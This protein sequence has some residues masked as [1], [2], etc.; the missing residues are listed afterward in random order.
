MNAFA[1]LFEALDQTTKTNARLDALVSYFNEASHEDAL[2]CIALLTHRRPKRTVNT[3]LLRE[4]AAEEAGIPLWL[5]E[6]TY[7]IVGDLAETIALVTQPVYRPSGREAEIHTTSLSAV[8]RELIALHDADEQTKRAYVTRQWSRFDQTERL[9]FNKLITGGF[10]MGV[11]A[12]NLTKALALFTGKDV[13]ALAHRLMGN[14]DPRT[15]RFADLVLSDDATADA[16][17]PYPFFLAY[18]VEGGTESLGTVE[19]YLAED[20]WDG[21]RA[22]VIV[23]NGELFIWSRGEELVTDKYP[24]LAHLV[25]V[26]PNGT[27]IDGELVCHSGSEVLPFALLQTRIGR[28]TVSKKLLA[29]APVKIIAY[30]LLEHGG[31]D[32]RMLPQHERRSMLEDLHAQTASESLLL[33]RLWV[34][35]SWDALA[36]VRESARERQSEGLMLKHRDAPYEVGRKRG[37]WWKWKLDPYTV[38]AVM[39]YAMRGHG[40][41]ANLYTDYTFAVWNADGELVPFTKAYSGLTD[42]EFAEVDRFVKANTLERF[43]P[44]RSVTPALVFE[45]A[46]EGIARSPR[47]KSGIA[48]RFPR[49]VRI[50]RDKKPEEAGTLGELEGLL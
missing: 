43:G 34:S 29:E 24:E 19:E 36:A 48:L 37:A 18:P 2:W 10:R 3:R 20:K 22:Q 1:R 8:M 13:N 33:S 30:D 26:L 23:R 40:R 50:R 4:W 42:Q 41:R 28:K 32:I 38:D 46:F 16:S 11:S 25:D 31:R 9:V 5:F 21:I 44:V 27:V 49:M 17:K 6:N 12:R 14:W 35:T 45:L 15:T 47:H 39:I 7:H